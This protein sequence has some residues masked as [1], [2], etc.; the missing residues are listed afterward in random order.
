M[1]LIRAQQQI[2][3]YKQQLK[4]KQSLKQRLNKLAEI[5]TDEGYIAQV[6]TQ[7]DGSFLLVENHCPICAA[8]TPCTGLC[9]LELETFQSVLGDEVNIQRK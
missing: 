2:E 9:A 6:Q 8:A 7:P 4:G 1:L 5:R 3:A